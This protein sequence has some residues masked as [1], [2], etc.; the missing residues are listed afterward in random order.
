MVK[1]SSTKNPKNY[2]AYF[3]STLGIVGASYILSKKLLFHKI[4]KILAT[5]IL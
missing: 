1:N 4:I 5:K 2:N 3:K